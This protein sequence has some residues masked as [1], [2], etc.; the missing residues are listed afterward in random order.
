MQRE[1]PGKGRSASM[2]TMIQRRKLKNLYL[3]IKKRNK[4]IKFIASQRYTKEY[5]REQGV[6]IKTG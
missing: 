4:E 6:N 3:S 2:W 5:T 1:I